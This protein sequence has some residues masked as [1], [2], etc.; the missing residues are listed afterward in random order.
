VN[1]VAGLLQVV[2]SACL[3][4]CRSKC[5]LPFDRDSDVSGDRCFDT[6]DV[7]FSDRP[8]PARVGVLLL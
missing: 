6:A 7:A 4:E 3:V 2:P 1:A 8:R 5:C